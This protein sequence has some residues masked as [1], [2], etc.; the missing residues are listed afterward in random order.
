[1]EQIKGLALLCNLNGLIHQVM[2]ND[3][4]LDEAKLNNKL[5]TNMLLTKAPEIKALIF[6]WK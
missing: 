1:M 4:D 2:R 6:F 5:F 3:F